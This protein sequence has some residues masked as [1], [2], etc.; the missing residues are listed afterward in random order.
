MDAANRDGP[1]E[2]GPAENNYR[3]ELGPGQT[4]TTIPERWCARCARHRGGKSCSVCGGATSE[5]P[6][7]ARARVGS[8]FEGG[9]PVGAGV[10]AE[11]RA[12]APA[13][14]PARV[15]ARLP[16]LRGVGARTDEG[17][18]LADGLRFDRASSAGAGAAVADPEPLEDE[19]SAPGP[20]LEPD[21]RE[22]EHDQGDESD[23]RDERDEQQP[24]TD[25]G[26]SRLAFLRSGRA[27]EH[28]LPESEADHLA[29]LEQRRA[30]LAR[31]QLELEQLERSSVRRVVPASEQRPS[32]LRVGGGV[33]SSPT[34]AKG[35]VMRHS[36]EQQEVDERGRP[37]HRMSTRRSA[38]VPVDAKY[39]ELWQNDKIDLKAWDSYAAAA[40]IGR[41]GPSAARDAG[42]I[43]DQMYVERMIRQRGEVG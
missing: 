37:I 41:D 13:P 25:R 34:P 39:A 9:S 12:A 29:E 14:E 24:E 16:F 38:S 20:M 40:L 23:E 28:E 19:A 5:P 4:I 30:E 26:F 1:E 43:A 31:A 42:T 15:A 7:A 17:G 18:R 10:G 2:I 11:A 27:R 3:P 33:L 35:A 6:E 8:V 32:A 21:E 22:P 36:Q